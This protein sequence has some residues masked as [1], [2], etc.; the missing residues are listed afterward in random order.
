MRVY[1]GFFF[2]L[3]PSVILETTVPLILLL[4]T[5][6]IYYLFSFFVHFVA[7]SPVPPLFLSLGKHTPKCCLLHYLHLPLASVS[8]FLALELSP[9]CLHFDNTVPILA[10]IL[11]VR[12]SALAFLSRISSRPASFAMASSLAGSWIAYSISFN[13][14]CW[15]WRIAVSRISFISISTYSS[16]DNPSLSAPWQNS[17]PAKSLS[18]ATRYRTLLLNSSHSNSHWN[19]NVTALHAFILVNF[20]SS[21]HCVTVLVRIF[22]TS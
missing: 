6:L 8:P 22:P 3:L 19:I 7:L 20:L 9:S 4:T 13:L 17:L 16:F 21:G 14:M 12:L 11:T 2:S 15:L 10:S 18:T 1:F 5:W